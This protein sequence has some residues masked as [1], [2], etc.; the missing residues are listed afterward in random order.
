MSKERDDALFDQWQQLCKEALDRAE[1]AETSAD[2]LGKLAT[3]QER[4][5]RYLEEQ[6]SRQRVRYL[7]RERLYSLN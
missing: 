1:H 5:I 7:Q 2:I 4:Q 3:A 6:L